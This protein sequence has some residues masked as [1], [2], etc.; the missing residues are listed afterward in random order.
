MIALRL[1]NS[2]DRSKVSAAVPDDL[3]GLVDQLPSLRTGEGVFLGE[4]M[5]I[6]SRVRVR[7][8]KQKPVGDDPKLPDVW[9]VPDRPD[10][11]LYTQAL[12]NWRAQSTSAEVDNNQD[13]G[14]GDP[15]DA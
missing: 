11:N 3:G 1:T 6:P 14:E 12:A 5:P 8:A 15:G 10:G 13:E 4:V 9:Q 2:A 7:K